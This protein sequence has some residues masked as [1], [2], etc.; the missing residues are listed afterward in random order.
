MSNPFNEIRKEPEIL[1]EII[2][3]EKKNILNIVDSIRE[4]KFHQ[5]VITARGRGETTAQ[6]YGKYL[7]DIMNHYIVSFAPPS[8][9]SLYNSPQK[10]DSALVIGLCQSGE[11]LDLVR[12]MSETRNQG[13]ITI[14]ITNN[15]KSTLAKK[16]EF[17]ICTHTSEPGK[18]GSIA[19]C[20]AQEFILAILSSS[21]NSDQERIDSIY[22][23]PSR[24]EAI[25]DMKEEIENISEQF[26]DIQIAAC[27]GRGFN[28]S[29]ALEIANELKEFAGIFSEASSSSDFIRG[30]I[31]MVKSNFPV[32]IFAPKGKTL[33]PLITL[34]KDLNA[35]EA[36][37]IIISDDDGILSLSDLPIKLPISL[38]EMVSPLITVMAG[39]MLIQ[40]FYEHN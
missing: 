21:L 22:E 30:P 34:A 1:R 18:E 26:K 11:E 37:T 2:S 31:S 36:R 8:V 12:V 16:S 35:R 25:L 27:V 32:F 20:V 3:K 4:R 13:G 10:M 38:D 33:P 23:I 28:Y 17:V 19:D 6:A 29:S 5:F 7:F 15:E 24:L 14:A 39:Q 40:K 9:Y